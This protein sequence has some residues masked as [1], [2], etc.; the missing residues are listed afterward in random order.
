MIYFY[1]C[2]SL[3]II[4][5]TNTLGFSI[6]TKKSDKEIQRELKKSLSAKA[7][8]VPEKT[9]MIIRYGSSIQ[10]CSVII[11]LVALHISYH[12]VQT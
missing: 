11:G 2:I 8:N 10:S 9:A 6:W 12:I 7:L 5:V 3:F 4:C 1:V